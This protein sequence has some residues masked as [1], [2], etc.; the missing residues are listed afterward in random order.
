MEGDGIDKLVKAFFAL[1]DNQSQDWISTVHEDVVLDWFGRCMIG[2]PQIRTFVRTQIEQT[3]HTIDSIR[4]CSPIKHRCLKQKSRKRPANPVQE[5]PK[6]DT[7]PILLECGQGDG[8]RISV[9]PPNRSIPYDDLILKAPKRKTL[10]DFK[11]DNNESLYFLKIRGTLYLK[12][13]NSYDSGEVEKKLK[14]II[15]AYSNQKV[16]LIVYEGTKSCKRLLAN[17]F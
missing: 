10:K 5:I 17:A 16:K 9:T 14:H 13:I 7:E 12:N 4:G 6:L 1:M 3:S 15:I 11:L 2:I 8:W